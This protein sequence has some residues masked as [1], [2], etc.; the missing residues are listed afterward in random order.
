MH[1][2]CIDLDR[3]Q[4]IQAAHQDPQSFLHLKRKEKSK[5]FISNCTLSLE[6]IGIACCVPNTE[7]SL[8]GG[9]TQCQAHQGFKT[10]CEGTKHSWLMNWSSRTSVLMGNGSPLT[11]SWKISPV[12]SAPYFFFFSRRKTS[13]ITIKFL[14]GREN[15]LP[16]SL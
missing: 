2:N 13:L 7:S 1:K 11:F 12:L 4:N 14:W 5:H 6:H 15:L 3:D 16:K 9:G 10:F 8:L